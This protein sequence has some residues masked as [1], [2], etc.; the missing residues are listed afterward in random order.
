MKYLLQTNAFHSVER[1]FLIRRAWVLFVLLFLANSITLAPSFYCH[2]HLSLR[3]K[4]NPVI[5][6][7]ALQFYVHRRYY[8]HEFLQSAQVCLNVCRGWMKINKKKKNCW[9]LLYA[10][11]F[12]AKQNKLKKNFRPNRKVANIARVLLHPHVTSPHVKIL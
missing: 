10:D 11:Y 12:S 7:N 8:P 3:G 9:N 6:V 5:S 2:N 4:I 1:G